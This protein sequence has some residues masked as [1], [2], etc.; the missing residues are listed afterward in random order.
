MVRIT[1]ELT[2]KNN[3]KI[4]IYIVSELCTYL[5]PTLGEQVSFHCEGTLKKILD[6]NERPLNP[7]HGLEGGIGFASTRL[8]RLVLGRKRRK[9]QRPVFFRKRIRGSCVGICNIN[10]EKINKYTINYVR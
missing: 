1:A 8:R 5:I 3:N 2:K 9:K 6:W 7:Q 10:N 4:I